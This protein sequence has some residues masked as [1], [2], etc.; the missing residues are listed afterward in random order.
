MEFLIK[1]LAWYQSL[2][3]SMIWV[4]SLGIATM[5]VAMAIGVAERNLYGVE[6]YFRGTWKN[7]VYQI[8]A[9][10]LTLTFISE[11]GMKFVEYW[12]TVPVEVSSPLNHFL[13]ALSGLGG[14]FIVAKIIRMF[15]KIR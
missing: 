10:F 3:W 14:G 7:Y 8:F 2:D 4:C 9:G 11:V 6:D 12:M 5:V 1:E 13:A 15:Q